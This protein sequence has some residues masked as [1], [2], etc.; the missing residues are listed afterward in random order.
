MTTPE[1]TE[2]D[3]FDA[4][5]AALPDPQ[6]AALETLR[7]QV[8]AAAPDAERGISYG[9]PA[10]RLHGRPLAGFSAATSHLSYLPFSPEVIRV[11]AER[12]AGWG[13]SK[14]AIRFTPEH[15][16]PADLVVSLVHARRA[17]LEASVSAA[18]TSPARPPRNG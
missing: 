12:L 3:R 13:T 18:S 11:H 8:A 2:S 7:D 4:Y 16:L 9:A 1:Q 15:P 14:G 10:F 5:L 17:E 6:R